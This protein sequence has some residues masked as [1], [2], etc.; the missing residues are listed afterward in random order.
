MPRIRT[1]A[2]CFLGLA[3]VVICHASARA[4]GPSETLLPDTTRGFISVGDIRKL[5]DQWN[6]TQLGQLLKDPVMKPF[7]DDLQRQ[8][9]ER[10]AALDEKLG[11]TIDDLRGV[12]GGEVT[13]AAI[14]P[15]DGQPAAVILV[16][17]TG[18]QPKAEALLKKVSE[19]LGK[20]GAKLEPKLTKDPSINVFRLPKEKGKEAEPGE[21]FAVYFVKDNLLAASDQL[22]VV[23]GILR[24]MAKKEAGSLADSAAFQAVMKRCQAD[25]GQATPQIRWYVQPLGYMEIM[26]ALR[27]ERGQVKRTSVTD[28]F[29]EQG[30]GAIQG[31]GGFVDFK[32]DRYELLHRT[33]VFAPPPYEKSMKML[34]FPN[35]S[36]FTPQRWVPAEIAGY[37]TFYFDVLNAFDNLGPL[38]DS[39]F[40]K[41]EKGVWE[42]VLNQ[43]EKERHGPKINLRKEFVVH[44]GNRVTMLTDYKVPIVTTSE[45]VFFAIEAKNE[46]AA[47]DAIAKMFKNDKEI[48]RREFEG[49]VIWESAPPPKEEVPQV[50]LELPDFGAGPSKPVAPLQKKEDSLFPNSAVAVA[51]GHLFIASHYDFMTKILH[52]ADPRD[53]LTQAIEYQTVSKAIGQLGV[54]EKAGQNFIRTDEQYRPTYELIRQNKMPQ[55]ETMLGRLLNTVLRTGKKGVPRKQE[56]EGSK[57]PE[58]DFVRRHL[59]PAAL[60]GVSEEKGWFIKGFVLPKG[61]SS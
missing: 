50:E 41:G 31:V 55:S 9:D 10:W 13:G 12:A 32:V 37:G 15:A 29:K 8:L 26:R 45:R 46:K 22:V 30:F 3:L 1:F 57:L 39:L 21:R 59:G 47:A 38:F 24:R 7:L 28:I 19:N 56:I 44:L 58:F 18:H 36:D 20:L 54:K 53:T 60:H 16:D 6:K 42:D 35:G 25:A 14:K 23:E 2:S 33:A 17:V 51:Y 49:H 40:G 5:A 11:L 34:K 61:A 4:A 43:L 27:S 48:R 52:Q